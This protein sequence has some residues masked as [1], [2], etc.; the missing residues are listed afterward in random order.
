[1]KWAEV[2]SKA[3]TVY[4]SGIQYKT[5]GEKING[6]LIKPACVVAIGGGGCRFV[7]GAKTYRVGSDGKVKDHP[8]V[9]V[10]VP[11]SLLID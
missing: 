4:L 1:M 5:D 9:V 7:A 8:N 2:I 10:F 6:K 3:G 11:G